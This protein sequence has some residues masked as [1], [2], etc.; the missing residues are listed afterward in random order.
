ML[1]NRRAFWKLKDAGVER[2]VSPPIRD[3]WRRAGF[4]TNL[5]D[6]YFLTSQTNK[7]SGFE[8]ARGQPFYG[9]HWF[10]DPP[11]VGRIREN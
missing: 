4:I 5:K 10:A 2:F 7:S 1:H 11:E 3:R 8:G 9:E 6:G